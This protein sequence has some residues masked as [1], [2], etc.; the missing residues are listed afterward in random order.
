MCLLTAPALLRLQLRKDTY[1][2]LTPVQ[3]LQV[4]R[5]PNRPTFLDIA[6]NIS[7]KVRRALAGRPS[8][9][10]C[11]AMQAG[12]IAFGWRTA[13]TGQLLSTCTGHAAWRVQRGAAPPGWHSPSTILPHAHD[14]HCCILIFLPSLPCPACPDCSL[15]S[16]TATAEGWMTPPWSAA[17][18]A[19]TASASCSLATR[20]GA[21]QRCGGAGCVSIRRR[22]A[23]V[24]L[25][26][27]VTRP[28]AGQA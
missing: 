8:C 20:R 23:A 24:G 3:K 9:L 22:A 4:A 27:R 21:T 26:S 16:C 11:F 12:G 17:W 19:S 25:R 28:A 10:L 5:H 7:D 13:A 2:R 14:A 1:N 18:A 15:W 6:L